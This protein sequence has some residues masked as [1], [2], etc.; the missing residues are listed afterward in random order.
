MRSTARS[1]G[2]TLIEL[3]IVLTIIGIVSTLAISGYM[4]ARVRS[5]EAAAVQTLTA[6]NR[7]QFTYRQTCGRQ[8]Y[9]PT[10]V[11][12]GTPPPGDTAGFVSPDL[13]VSDPL[14]KSGYLFQLSG[15]AATEG[16]QSCTGAVP[17]DTYRLTADPLRSG[18]GYRFF[19]TNT[20]RVIY[21]DAAS[22]AADMPETGP[23]GHGREIR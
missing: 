15:T 18:W 1:R 4:G 13:A 23:P 6:V 9:A 8:R 5:H 19:A 21:A 17:L 3:L 14:Q 20:D 22:F 11:N 7:A 10:L 2:F 16:E 12:L